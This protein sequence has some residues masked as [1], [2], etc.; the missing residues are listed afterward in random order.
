MKRWKSRELKY[1][2]IALGVALTLGATIGLNRASPRT[3][4]SSPATVVNT[5][6]VRT[7]AKH[8][9][10]FHQDNLIAFRVQGNVTVGFPNF[11]GVL[12]V[13]F[14]GHFVGWAH[15]ELR[16]A[17]EGTPT[18]SGSISLK[19][20]SANLEVPNLSVLTGRVTSF[21]AIS[22]RLALTS[23]SGK[24]YVGTFFTHING[25]VRTF[26]GELTLKAATSQVT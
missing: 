22:L 23:A 21:N 6:I 1:T 8:E 12:P 24:V 16:I 17:V 4:L 2:A 3:A 7:I 19:S 18:P 9:A 14:F 5:A 20:S 15:K 13:V 26:T 11:T 25:L 10:T